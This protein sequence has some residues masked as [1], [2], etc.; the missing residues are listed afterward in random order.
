MIAEEV[1][2]KAGFIRG[3]RA[4]PLTAF[5][6]MTPRPHSGRVHEVVSYPN[7]VIV[8]WRPDGKTLAADGFD[9]SKVKLWEVA[10]GALL[11]DLE[12]P[13]WATTR[14]PGARMD[15]SWCRQP[16]TS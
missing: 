13:S 1:E 15:R 3:L 5:D 2:G 14:S 6:H 10:S 8:A 9:D 12:G 7:A 11:R 4:R 16:M